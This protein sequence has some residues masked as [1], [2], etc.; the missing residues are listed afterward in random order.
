MLIGWDPLG[1]FRAV[2]S[3]PYQFAVPIPKTVAPGPYRLTAA[4]TS[5]SQG[6]NSIL[7]AS[8]Q[9]TTLVERADEPVRLYVFPATLTLPP[10]GRISLQVTGTFA[11]GDQVYLKM[12]SKTI[13]S[14]D[15]PRVATVEPNS[16]VTA[17]APGTAKITLATAKPKSKSLSSSPLRSD[18]PANPV[19]FS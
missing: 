12:S 1:M 3:P 10:S 18:R 15:S 17:H 14:S 7:V 19:L 9:I 5:P 13:Y 11:D 16:V 2:G 6:K 4:G 8:N